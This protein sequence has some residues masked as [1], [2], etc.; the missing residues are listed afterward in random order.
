MTILAVFKSR[1][2]ALDCISELRREGIPAQPVANPPE[3]RVGCGVSARFEEN[4]LPRAQRVIRRKS[5]S[6]FAGYLKK[7][8]ASYLFL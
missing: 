3:A 6:A 2:Q 5:Y 1:A 4:F 8:G 7:T